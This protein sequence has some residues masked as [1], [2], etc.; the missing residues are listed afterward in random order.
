MNKISF[1][2]LTV[3]L[4]VLMLFSI[5]ACKEEPQQPAATTYTVTFDSDG[6]SSVAPITVAEGAKVKKPSDPTQE[7]LYFGGWWTKNTKGNYKAVYNFS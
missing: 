1:R 7:G 4:S 5:V 2:V 6:G 3:I